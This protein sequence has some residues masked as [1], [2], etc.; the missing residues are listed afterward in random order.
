LALSGYLYTTIIRYYKIT[1]PY[2][3]RTTRS[4]TLATIP[5]D[6]G[7]DWGDV[8][9]KAATL[10][11]M[12]GVT[13]Q[14]GDI[15][16]ALELWQQSLELKEQI[17]DVQGK[18]TTL[19]NMAYMAGKTGDQPQQLSLN[20][21]A[22]EAFASARAYVDLCTVLT[23]LGLSAPENP[24]AYLAQA[25]WLGLQIQV[26]LADLVGCLRVMYNQVP[27]GDPMEALLATTA[28]C[29]CQIRGEGHPQLEELRTTSLKML[30]GAAVA[31]GVEIETIEALSDWMAQQQLNDPE[32]FLP[33]L[34]QR[35]EAM[36][37]DRW[38]FDPK[39]FRR[40][41]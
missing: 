30:E 24:E 8:Q 39:E 20:L 34:N 13:A 15:Q 21:Q 14:Q 16:R 32:I 19:N 1:Y 3:F 25:I 28:F 37:A 38:L 12:A 40:Q 2:I 35:L 36:V 9:G 29:Y 41:S 26:P 33:Q 5:G 10:S 27:K 17:G 11:N 6:L 7:T 22:A 4:S 23:N 18:A 31:Q